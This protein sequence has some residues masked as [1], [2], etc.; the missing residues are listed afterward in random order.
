MP[1]T[2]INNEY[3]TLWYHPETKI[4]HHQFHQP[5]GGQPLR[6][7]L[8]K[9]LEA[10]QEHGAYKWLSDD[11]GNS[12]MSPEDSEWG[13]NDWVPRVIA[14]GWKYWAVVMP[15]KVIG[16][17]NMQRFIKANSELGII[18]QVFSNPEEA[19]KWLETQ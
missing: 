9:G 13:T 14:A 7:V 5:I 11:R 16:Q 3:A 12:A 15:A 18:V 10:F 19:M 17:M 6:D 1:T 2:I 4:V 8:N